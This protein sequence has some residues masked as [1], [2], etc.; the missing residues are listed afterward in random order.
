MCV[1]CSDEEA[2][3]VSQNCRTKRQNIDR[4]KSEMNA[5]E[6]R[7]AAVNGQLGPFASELEARYLL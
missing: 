4:L 7:A 1:L 3:R 6:Q 5:T 2:S